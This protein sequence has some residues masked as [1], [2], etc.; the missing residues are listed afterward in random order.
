MKHEFDV[1]NENQKRAVFSDK[2]KVLVMSGAG[3]GKTKVLTNRIAYLLQSGVKEEDIVAFTFTNKAAREMKLRLN[4]ILE[5]ETTAFIG[6]FHSFCY[7]AIRDVGNYSKLGFRYPPEIITEYDKGRIIK[8]I[9]TNYNK[10]YSN[11]PFVSAISKLKNGVKIDDIKGDDL[12]ILN[13]VYKEYQDRLLES[14]MIDFDDMVPMFLKLMD[15][16]KDY[17]QYVCQFEHVL[18]DECQDTNLIQYNLIKKV[19]DKHGRIFMVGDEDQLIYSFRSSD[20]EILKDFENTCNEIIILNE[21][22]RCNKDILG[23]ANKLISF[24][25][26]R[27]D[28]ALISNIESDTKVEYKDFVSQT[29]E[30][31]E[32]VNRI[33]QLVLKGNSY[34]SIAILYRNNSQ[35]SAIEKVLAKEKIP[36]TIFGGKAFFEYADI[37]AIIYT[38]R[39]L[40]NPFNVIAFMAAYNRPNNNIEWYE[41]KE[42]L[43][44][45][46]RQNLDIISF[47]KEYNDPRFYEL[48]KKYS[49]LKES[50]DRL[51][52]IDFFNE[53]LHHLKYNKY[54]KDSSNQ[55]PEYQ[56]LMILKDMLKDLSKDEV[57]TFF[58]ELLLE[59]SEINKPIGVSLLTIHKS[60]GLEFNTVFII[61]CN[62]G[63]IPGY[64]KRDKDLEED[65]RVFYVAITRAKQNLFLYSSQVHYVNGQLFK[66]KPSSFLEEAGIKES[67]VMDFFGNY[68]YNK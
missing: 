64:S 33:K 65:R 63:I 22:Y 55:K 20:I 31:L 25:Q 29:E 13:S 17:C 5:R 14:S 44:D 53:I 3:A 2:N 38:Y 28:K 62:D 52:P 57:K 58:N 19:S 60:K 11:I 24:N 61:G 59:Q 27:L 32:V 9:L 37:R 30:S 67:S 39:L 68:W 46:S 1:L 48:G 4:K 43:N 41:A 35:A 12:L 45:Y 10:D 23:V 15:L 6:T 49:I 34:D 7:N 66:L 26:N 8:D 18:V 42:F 16:D 56:R 21:N 36:Y 51:E 50:I 54:L 40:Y 47:L